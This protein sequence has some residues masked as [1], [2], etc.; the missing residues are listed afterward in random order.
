[1]GEDRLLLHLRLLLLPLLL[2]L[3]DDLSVH[4]VRA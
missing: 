3:R 1:V 4:A 2:L